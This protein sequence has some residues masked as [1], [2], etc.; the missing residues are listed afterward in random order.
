MKIVVFGEQRPY[1][2]GALVGDDVIDL[3]RADPSLPSDLRGL[4][5]SGQPALEKTQRVVDQASRAPAGSVQ[6]A[7]AVKIRAPYPGVRVACVGGNYARHLA[8]MELQNDPNATLESITKKARDGGQWGFWKV[9]ADAAGPDDDVPIPSRTEYHDYEGELAIVLGKSAKNFTGSNIDDLI[10]GMTLFNDWSIRDGMGG[11]PRAMSYNLAK[12]F[13]G[14]TSIGPC[15]VVGE[16]K[17]D[18]VP[19]VTKINGQVRQ[20][21]NTNEMIFSFPE[22]LEY[23][24]RD[25]TFVPG[26]II[27]GGTC[28]G[29]AMDATK[30]LPDGTRPKD[31][32]LKVG[33]VVEIESPK[34]GTLRNRMVRG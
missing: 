11:A 17:C 9:I 24:S 21:Y 30:R 31:L 16:L 26:D 4:I 8:G 29:T 22:V 32:F 18:D 25:F 14:C 5:E 10:W 23:L 13:D 33:D 34:I 28:S 7:N 6:K 27:S 12:N 20:D 1:R 19:V 15:I 2:V 3:N